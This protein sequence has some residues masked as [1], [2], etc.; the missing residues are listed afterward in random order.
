MVF[1]LIPGGKFL[2]GAQPAGPEGPN[3]DPD[4]LDYEGPVHEV[5][6]APFL[7]SKTET[8]QGQW[9]RLSGRNPSSLAPGG[10]LR[11]LDYVH[12]LRFPVERVSWNACHALLPRFGLM[13][14]TEAQWEY[15]CRAGSDT[16]WWTGRQRESIA[17]AANIAD[18][19]AMRWGA[20]WGTLQEW[21]GGAIDDGYGGHAP[22][23]S[24]RANAFGLHDVHGNVAEWT[25]DDYLAYEHAKHRPGDGLLLGTSSGSRVARG[26]AFDDSARRAG[27]ARRRARL[28]ADYVSGE[29][30]VRAV[31]EIVEN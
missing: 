8:T 29:Y 26:G 1:V 11:N 31:R 22:V 20:D 18:A 14:P 13:L 4:A 28:P 23:G 30:G 17:G 24:F 19:A 21:P 3:Y 27:S 6:L 12:D 15:A 25:R 10:P 5:E 2:M 7:I 9:M 16:P